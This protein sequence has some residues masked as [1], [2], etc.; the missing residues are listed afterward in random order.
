M[1]KRLY[2]YEIVALPAKVSETQV[3]KPVGFKTRIYG[4]KSQRVALRIYVKTQLKWLR[5]NGLRGSAKDLDVI[6][7]RIS[8]N[9]NPR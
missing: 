7:T 1:S 5:K 2:N 9:G 6:V 3:G 4:V 8:K